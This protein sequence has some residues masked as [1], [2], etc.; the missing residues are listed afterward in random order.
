MQ[1]VFLAISCNWIGLFITF[2]TSS[3]SELFITFFTSSL[4]ELFITFFTSS[5]SELFITFLTSSLSELSLVRFVVD[6][7][8]LT[9]VLQCYDSSS[10]FSATVHLIYKIV[11]ILT[12]N[13]SSGMLNCTVAV[14]SSL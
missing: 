1:Q 12:C 8:D 3:L 13:V 10:C 14:S 5:L 9:I 4:S 11:P 6:L 2:F 7:V